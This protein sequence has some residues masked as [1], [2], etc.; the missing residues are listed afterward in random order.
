MEKLLFVM[1]L[2][3]KKLPADI[4]TP[5]EIQVTISISFGIACC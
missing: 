3:M 2:E 4:A 5:L 1:A